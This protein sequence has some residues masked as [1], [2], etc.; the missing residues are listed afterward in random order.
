M[1]GAASRAKFACRAACVLQFSTSADEFVA[2]ASH[3]VRTPLINIKLHTELLL[4]T[5]MDDQE[6][7]G[8]GGNDAFFRR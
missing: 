7:P 1:H 6:L 8:S 4:E 5:G 2:N 3:E